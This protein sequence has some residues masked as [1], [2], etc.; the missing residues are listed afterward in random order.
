M[1]TND[2]P[3]CDDIVIARG[4]Q[5]KWCRLQP[6]SAVVMGMERFNMMSLNSVEQR[7]L[8]SF[9]PGSVCGQNALRARRTNA[10]QL[11]GIGQCGLVRLLPMRSHDRQLCV[12]WESLRRRYGVSVPVGQNCQANNKQCCQKPYET[13]LPFHSDRKGSHFLSERG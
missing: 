12:L 11:S 1:L 4:R 7:S 5:A 9:A 6:A 13:A 3:Q 10:I 8:S 2:V